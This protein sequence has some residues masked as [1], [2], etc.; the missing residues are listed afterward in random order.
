[1]YVLGLD[2]NRFKQVHSISEKRS[3]CVGVHTCGSKTGNESSAPPT[4]LA[5]EARLFVVEPSSPSSSNLLDFALTSESVVLGFLV[6]R[7]LASIR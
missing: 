4:E 7:D 5:T 6:K 2:A 1:M 3:D